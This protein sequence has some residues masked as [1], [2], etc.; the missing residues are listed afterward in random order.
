MSG[1][2][3]HASAGGRAARG[4]RL[5]PPLPRPGSAARRRVTGTGA[6]GCGAR[7]GRRK[8]MPRR[9]GREGG[10]G[11]CGPPRHAAGRRA[12]KPPFVLRLRGRGGLP[13]PSEVAPVPSPRSPAHPARTSSGA[14]APPLALPALG[15]G[16]PDLLAPRGRPPPVPP[17]EAREGEGGGG[18]GRHVTLPA[19]FHHSHQINNFSVPPPPTLPQQAAS[20]PPKSPHKQPANFPFQPGRR[21]AGPI[22]TSHRPE[23]AAGKVGA[24]RWSTFSERPRG[25]GSAGAGAGEEGAAGRGRAPRDC[26]HR[27]RAR[28]TERG[29][30]GEAAAAV[31]A[32]PGTAGP[33]HVFSEQRPLLPL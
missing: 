17:E 12:H 31:C 7:A 6:P 1:V 24:K 15:S 25:A 27:L 5:C 28:R 20:A 18:G 14:R 26:L 13:S 10:A 9:R 11:P 19:T 3:P 16:A 23:R 30:G 21:G 4:A 32:R 2:P 8:R 22:T 29:A 33:G